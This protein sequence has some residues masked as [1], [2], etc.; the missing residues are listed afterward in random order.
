M[1]RILVQPRYP[2]CTLVRLYQDVAGGFRFQFIDPLCPPGGRSPRGN[3]REDVEEARCAVPLRQQVDQGIIAVDVNRLAWARALIKVACDLV[4]GEIRKGTARVRSKLIVEGIALG[5]ASVVIS[6]AP[7][8][9][10]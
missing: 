4:I 5:R 7:P 3:D 2:G 9:L 10:Q 6:Q 1:G 8:L